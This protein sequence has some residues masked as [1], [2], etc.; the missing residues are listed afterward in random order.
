MVG[1]LVTFMTFLFLVFCFTGNRKLFAS[2]LSSQIEHFPAIGRIHSFPEAML[3]PALPSRWLKCSL[4][5]T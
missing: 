5:H 2:L 1:F 4:R 3:V